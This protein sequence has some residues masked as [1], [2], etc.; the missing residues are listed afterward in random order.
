MP[1][2][3]AILN[4]LALIA[5]E[6]RGLAVA[7]HVAGLIVGIYALS[8]RP[9]QRATAMLVVLPLTSVSA[10]A[11]WSGNPFNGATFLFLALLMVLAAT[12]MGRQ[13]I[14]VGHRSWAAAGILLVAFGLIYPHFLVT[15]SWVSYLYASPFGL[16]PCPTLAVVAGISLIFDAFGS[17]LWAAS[18]VVASLAYGIIGVV[19][20]GVWIDATLIVGALTLM[21]AEVQERLGRQSAVNP[22]W[23]WRH[24]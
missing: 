15:N 22:D 24:S 6:W 11:W 3:D 1:G 10:L 19:A 4:G 21:L 9:S 20:L 2:P 12:R 18:L 23:G 8:Q 5:N 13:A 17:R 14:A 16:I 7:W